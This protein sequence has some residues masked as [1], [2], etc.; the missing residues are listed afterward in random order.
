M[1]HEKN[2]DYAILPPSILPFAVSVSLFLGL[3]GSVIWMHSLNDANDGSNPWL[4]LAGLAGLLFSLFSWWREMI[5]E[6]QAGMNTAVVRIGLREG[7]IL[8]IISEVFFFVA[9][10]WNYLK[11][12]LFP[13]RA[14]EYMWPPAGVEVFD[15]W[16][17][18]LINTLILLLSGTFVTWAHHAIS[19]EGDNKTMARG[20]GIAVLLGIAFTGFQA[21]EY[22]HATFS[23][24]HNVYGSAFFLATGFH[25]FHVIMGTTFLFIC[26]LRARAAQF[27]REQHVGFE[28][29]AWYWHFV[30]VVWIMLFIIIYVWVGR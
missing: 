4:M 15:P 20:I 6:A 5:V 7:F 16:H 19:H 8:F 13:M 28:T 17:L 21:Y 26:W 22:S 11:H 30:D 23:L 12:G 2:H 9:W 24:S 1:A 18:P 14:N 3:S 27:T 25:G 29:A 10:F